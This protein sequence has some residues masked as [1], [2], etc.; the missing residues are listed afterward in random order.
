MPKEKIERRIGREY[1]SYNDAEKKLFFSFRTEAIN[2]LRKLE[3]VGI[4]AFI[5]GSVARGDVS[6][7]SDIDIYIPA[8]ISSFRLDIIPDFNFA[9][10]R[11]IMGTP[12]STIRGV[13]IRN[14]NISVSFPLSIPREREIE[15]YRFSGFLYQKDLEQ[16]VRIAGVNK[17]LLLVEP[18]GKGYWISSAVSNKNRVIEVLRISQQ[19]IDER[20]RVLSRR[21]KIGRTGLLIDYS[22][23]PNENFEQALRRLSSRN[24]IVRRKIRE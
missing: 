13:L 2:I 14:D 12:N 21:D 20:I 17:K 23:S 10:R 9:D 22:L 18:E 16:N 6:N 15:F 8:Q 19:I 7:T 5:H 1:H 3:E 4:K 11:I 24:V